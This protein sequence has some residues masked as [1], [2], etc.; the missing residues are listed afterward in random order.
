MFHHYHPYMPILNNDTK[1]LIVGTLPPPRF[2]DKNLKL[3]DVNFSYGSQDNQ[4]WQVLN[5]LFNLN[6]LFD[7]SNTAIEQR[8]N[9]LNINKI[10]ICDIV[11]SCEREKID[12]SDIGMKNI[13]LRDLISYIKKYP[14]IQ[15]II[16]T[17]KNTKNSPEYFFRKQLLNYKYKLV[18]IENPNIREHNLNIFN[19]TLTLYSLTSPSNAANRSIGANIIFKTKRLENKNYSTFDFRYEEYKI[20]FN[21][22]E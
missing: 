7:N 14:N 9:F 6:L 3:K 5:K 15:R 16:F 21:M 20:A 2:C 18:T 12:A 11:E 1:I 13:I 22:N 10:G 17:G 8:I 19:R 4:L